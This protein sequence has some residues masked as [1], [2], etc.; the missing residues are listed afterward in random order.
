MRPH[1]S[2]VLATTALLTLATAPAMAGGGGTDAVA[3]D[4]FTGRQD[5]VAYQT[6]RD[7]HEGVYL[8]HPDGTDDHEVDFGLDG[9][10][11]L[12]PD[13]SPDGTRLV[14]TTRNRFPETLLEHDL[15]TGESR[16]LFDCEWPCAGDDEPA[17]SPDGSKV[18][19]I[20]YF[21]PFSDE[22]PADCSL[23][24]G[25]VETGETRRV[26][27]NEG[28]DREYFPRWSP[29]GTHLTYHRERPADDGWWTSAVF[30]IRTD[31]TD[32]RRLTAFDL[33]G[34]TPDWSP[35]GRWIVFSTHPLGTSPDRDS[36]LYRIRPDGTG[37]QRLTRIHSVRAVQPRYTPDGRWIVFTADR[38]R[39]RSLWALPAAGGTPVV[40]AHRER[41]YT[42]GTWQPG[43]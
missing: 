26:T 4:P 1:T 15:A 21:G 9:G 27:D 39:S 32:E 40:L 6:Y 10:Y 17:Y 23:W 37:L 7:G 42:H 24:I 18:A 29:D 19:F 34:G 28:C 35:D 22:G 30:T 12:L 38:P 25:D 13:W 14:V 3:P 5:W 11:A 20:R 33:V 2:I 43:T 31:G 8:V 36:E 16:E 41:I